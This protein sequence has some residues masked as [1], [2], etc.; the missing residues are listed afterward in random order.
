[1]ESLLRWSIEHSGPS[2]GPP[3]PRTD[4]DPGII[5][6]I[7]GKSDAELMKEDLAVA[8]DPHRSEDARVE[9]LDHL[10]MLIEQIDNA[11]NL[12]KLKMWAPLHS[13]L[14]SP[15]STDVIV[16]QTLWVIGTALQNNPAAQ[17]TYLSS[18]PLPT[19]T[20]F[21]LSTALSGLL[22]HNAPAVAA[23]DQEG[24]LR[25]V[26]LLNTLLTPNETTVQRGPIH[27]NSHAAN[28]VDPGRAETSSVEQGILADVVGA[29]VDPLPYGEDGDVLEPDSR[30][31]GEEYTAP[32]DLYRRL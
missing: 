31:R 11:N 18:N 16:M 10:E 14:T 19:L 8:I 22:K 15:D 12:E 6:V 21:L 23:L 2:A 30:F 25:P 24:W 32:L 5:D 28:L 3:Q 4:L 20:A 7:L 9:A 27:P 1:M 13:L 29:L 17:E 26:F